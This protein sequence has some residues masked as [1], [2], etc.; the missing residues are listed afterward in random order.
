MT[1]NADEQPR[2]YSRAF[3]N[4]VQSDD[5]VVGLLAYALYK[6]SVR[7]EAEQGRRSSGD[8][9]NPPP[10][11]VSTYR[12]AAER[13]LTEVVNASIEAAKPEIQ[14]SATL[15]S[16]DKAR[17]DLAE[18]ITSRTSF[19]QALLANIIAW[20]FTLFVAALILYLARGPSPEEVLSEAADKLAPTAPANAV[21]NRANVTR[22]LPTQNG[23]ER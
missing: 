15:D 7:E 13:E 18:H 12:Q 17:S 19:G 23:T 3:D 8:T 10:T 22:Q 1:G 20:G 4:F 2:V 9:R 5:D 14:R 6:R 21:E 16:I 11:V